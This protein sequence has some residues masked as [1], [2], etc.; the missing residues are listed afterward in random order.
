MMAASIRKRCAWSR[1][2]DRRT[3]LYAAD[4]HT[5]GAMARKPRRLGLAGLRRSQRAITAE[6]PSLRHRERLLRA[7]GQDGLPV[8]L[9]IGRSGEVEQIYLAADPWSEVVERLREID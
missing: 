4:V 8:V 9:L 7:I 1:S 2:Q 6:L 5:L 3:W